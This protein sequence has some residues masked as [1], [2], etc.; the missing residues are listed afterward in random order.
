MRIALLP[1]ENPHM[2]SR[3]RLSDLG[4]LSSLYHAILITACTVVQAVV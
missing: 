2:S 3:Y 4:N 1:I